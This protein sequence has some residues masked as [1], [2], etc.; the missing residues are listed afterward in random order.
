MVFSLTPDSANV[1]SSNKPSFLAEEITL[2]EAMSPSCACFKIPL[3]RKNLAS[4]SFKIPPLF[5]SKSCCAAALATRLGPRF[6]SPTLVV[7]ANVFEAAPSYPADFSMLP[8]RLLNSF[9]SISPKSKA[10]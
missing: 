2:L 7:S 6:T 8:L 10:F 4:L 1:R 3:S 5:S 9:S